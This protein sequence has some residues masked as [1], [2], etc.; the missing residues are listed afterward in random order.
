MKKT[1]G[2]LV[3]LI[4]VAGVASF[5]VSCKQMNST[6][7][8]EEGKFRY[9]GPMQTLAFEIERTM[10]PATGRVPWDQLRIA[11]ETADATRKQLRLLDNFT[12][13]LSWSER[14]P[15]SDVPGPS[16]GN[17]R[18]N[19]GI[20]S[21]RV[22]ALMVDSLD[23][24]HKTVFVG[25]VAGGLWKTT[26]ITT[27]PANWVLI[28]D[29]LSNL[30]IADICQ[31]PRPGFQNIMYLCTGE[32]YGNSDA[33]RGVGVFKSVDAGAT[34]NFLSSTS[35]YING[36]R[37]LCDYLGNVYLGTRTSGL[38][39]STDG[40]SSWTNITPSGIG[41]DVCDL[42]ITS[43][44]VVGRLH[45]TT[46]IFSTSGYRY[47]DN[48]ET[49]TSASGWNAATTAFTT[50]NQRTELAVSGNTLFALPDNSSHLV[51]TI[52]K[53]TDGGANWAST[54][55]QPTS[56]WANGQGWYDL[57]AAIN[58][59]DPENCIV[60]G[61]DCYETT[62]GGATW[63]KISA[64][65]GTSG[66]YVHADQH[67]I[68]WWD[69]GTKLLFG[70]DGGVHYSSDG[71][72]TIRDRN[73][74]LR[75]KQFYSCAIHPV[76]TNY[77]IGGA[78]DNGMH[79]F[80]NPG[81]SS[82]VEFAGGDG[83]YSAIDQDE[84]QYQFGS[85]VYNVYRRSTNSGST[86]STP[87][88]NQSTG[89][90]VNPWDYDNT[91]NRIYACNSAGNYLRWDNPQTGAT[92]TV[93]T[94]SAFGSGNVSAVH[95]SPF[96]ANRV[97]FGTG[98]ATIFKVD[99]AET[100]SPTALAITPSG[101]SG[102]VNCIVTGSAEQNL[103]ACYSSYGVTNVW[104]SSNGGTSWTACDGNLPNMPVRWGMFHPDD[105]NKAIIATETGIWETDL[106][107]GASTV[108]TP[109]TSF[110]NV[111]TDMIKYRSSDRT[112]LAATHGRGMW[113]AVIPSVS[114]GFSFNTPAA[115]TAT[116]PAPTSMSVTLGTNSIGGF[117]GPVT[118]S[119]TSGVPGGTFV[120]FSPNPVTP[121][122][123]SVVTLNNTNLL[124][125]G[126]YNIT[127]QGTAVGATT[128]TVNV[129][130]TINPGTGPTIT[131][132]PASQT[133]CEGS[134]V[135]FSVVAAGTYQWQISTN[136]GGTWTNISGATSASYTF[137]GVT[138]ALSGNQYRCVVSNT[139]A[140]TNSNAAVLTVN[141]L[142]SITTHPQ[143]VTVCSGSSNT[144]S[145][146]AT[147]TGISY[148]WQSSASGC[149]GPWTNISGATS[150]SYLLS[151]ITTGMTNTGYRCVVSGSCTPA[152]TSNCA[153]LTV[154]T[155]VAI[156]TQPANQAVCAGSNTSFAVAGSGTGIIY[157]WQINTGSGFTN[158]TDGG[159]YSGSAAA[160]LNITGAIVSMNTYQYR[161][162]LSTASCTT[163]T[164]SN[165][166]TLTVNT[167]PAISAHPQ[168]VTLCRSSSTSFSVTAS[169]TSISYQWQV[170]STGTGFVNILT[171]SYYSGIT[172][173]TL[174]V[175][176]TTSGM[177]TGSYRYRCVV[178]GTC[179]PAATSS[180]AILTVYAPVV[181]SAQPANVELCSGGNATFTVAGTSVPAIIYQWQVSTDG[182]TNW[183][184]VAGANAASL[185]LNGVITA[186]SGNRYR[187][188]LSNAT[189]TTPVVSN[190]AV[191]TVRATPTISLTQAPVLSSLLPGQT[192]T[193]T[194]SPSA[195]TGGSQST[196]TTS[197][198]YNLNP[199]TVTGNTYTVDVEHTGSYQVAVRETWVSGLFCSALSASIT[200]DA[201][202]SSRLF[203]FPTPN[204]G[205]FTV[206]Y[207]NNG[208]TATQRSLVI[209]DS[210]GSQV[211][212][213]VFTV[214][215]LY[216]L[217]PVN[218]T[219]ANTGIYYVVIGDANGTKLATGKVH[220]K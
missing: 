215:G 139:C 191:M 145:V 13:A 200:I 71:G 151:G 64:W 48:P 90:F 10:D 68:Q 43:T 159:V 23:A 52:W 125:A 35:S 74:G 55:S 142:P 133:V 9:D 92:T 178:S 97:F 212:N 91:G 34:W 73:V 89:R 37:I 45:V 192:T 124:T 54:T 12:E 189:C 168:N 47:T 162:L 209:F 3:L 197:W 98:S 49:A 107:N 213:K 207:Y 218:L 186:L 101:A 219:G 185:A 14:G 147:G 196:F 115:A 86:W 99:N 134:G 156:T 63:T 167:L 118:L 120:S 116:C 175:N 104:I 60:G 128:Q 180:A 18:A 56:G 5:F 67:D 216:T 204:D 102:Y 126:T 44:A 198:T 7:K 51:P 181:V 4:V 205:N 153:L 146:A 165:A 40:G 183:T 136:G 42:E 106:L 131:T 25:S 69:G 65:V 8:E 83:C 93:V 38:L 109:N 127:V 195:Q 135:T 39:R 26:D 179:S 176:G 141:T 76:T 81:L 111:R 188:L 2:L 94:V 59:A 202:V 166:A 30:A 21:G 22:R 210:R 114:S 193:L 85:Y 182:G 72:T 1:P 149:S 50:F 79:Q 184:N 152:A 75:I 29:R 108:W 57:S 123:S 121:G 19:S 148:Q 217:L 70:C 208:G 77:F 53:S 137:T 78:Q 187:C 62:N 132:Q 46:G 144:F 41:S 130:Y 112:V 15:I 154:A 172:S 32:S 27:A 220:I 161:C 150:A 164:V 31:D 87:V 113:T 170:D 138:A 110:P 140:S 174:I 24:T 58:P 143:S 117:S 119:A 122:N 80:S 171:G 199:L 95:V 160:T 194:A 11:I 177:E 17:T 82:S 201:G 214:T 28:D 203:I 155:S 33:V 66:Q 84:P 16:N 157:Q 190:A 20:P 96:T 129:A 103:M 6:A 169:G 36:T 105:N 206:S 61:I 173:A 88:N 211:Y 158:L 163:P 100:A